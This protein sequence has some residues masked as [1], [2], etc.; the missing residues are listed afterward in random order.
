MKS[1]VA[2]KKAPKPPKGGERAV[3]TDK[4]KKDYKPP[5]ATTGRLNPTTGFVDQGT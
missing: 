2:G 5:E 1:D 3:K 4:F